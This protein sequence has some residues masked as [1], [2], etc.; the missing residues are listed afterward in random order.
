VQGPSI[1]SK[2]KAKCFRRPYYLQ[3]IW[4]GPKHCNE[5]ADQRNRH[6]STQSRTRTV[7]A[8]LAVNPLFNSPIVNDS[9]ANWGTARSKTIL[10]SV[11]RMYSPLSRISHLQYP[12][13]LYPPAC[14]KT[15]CAHAGA[16]SPTGDWVQQGPNGVTVEKVQTSDW[17]GARLVVICPLTE[18]WF[19]LFCSVGL[20]QLHCSFTY[21]CRV[22]ADIL[23]PI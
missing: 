22:W 23:F 12:A 11:R 9:C 10:I 1:D 2:T 18:V 20:H 15:R 14:Q 3:S 6:T 21:T 5:G 19:F 7:P 8:L 4:R 17:V 13:K 16:A